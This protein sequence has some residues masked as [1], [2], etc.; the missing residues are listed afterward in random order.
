MEN[1]ARHGGQIAY[2]IDPPLD[3]HKV[4]DCPVL[5][6]ERLIFFLPSSSV[7][8]K[9]YSASLVENNLRA[10]ANVI[11]PGSSGGNADNAWAS[12]ASV[13]PS[14]FAA[15]DGA[16]A[17]ALNSFPKRLI[18]PIQLSSHAAPH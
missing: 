17:R 13:V 16:A 4:D 6:R 14:S 18:I 8:P 7:S 9:A 5:R 2:E 11:Q 10:S 12:A 3:R 1:L 15:S